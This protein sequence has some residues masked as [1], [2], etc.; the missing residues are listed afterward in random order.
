MYDYRYTSQGQCIVISNLCRTINTRQDQCVSS[1]TH[2]VVSRSVLLVLPYVRLPI[3]WS[4]AVCRQPYFLRLLI[5]WSRDYRN[6][7]AT[8]ITIPIDYSNDFSP[9]NSCL[10]FLGTIF[11]WRDVTDIMF[12]C[13]FIRARDL[14]SRPNRLCVVWCVPQIYRILKMFYWRL[15]RN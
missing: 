10:A 2:T 6:D 9:I 11:T 4:R 14:V 7:R 12:V 15:F 3:Q 13:F 5:R 8:C 1:P